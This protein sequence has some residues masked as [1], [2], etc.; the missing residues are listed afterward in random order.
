MLQ[1]TILMRSFIVFETK[2]YIVLNHLT[3][4]ICLSVLTLCWDIFRFWELQKLRTEYA[5]S[6]L[7]SYVSIEQLLVVNLSITLLSKLQNSFAFYWFCR[8]CP[9]S[10]SGSSIHFVI[11]SPPIR[12]SHFLF[13]AFHG[14]DTFEKYLAFIL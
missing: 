6:Y 9:S 7:T 10:S 13:L 2:V 11:M 1:H 12:D 5:A 14:F 3:R 8:L 4:I